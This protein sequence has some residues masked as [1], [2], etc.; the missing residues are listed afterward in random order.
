MSDEY[1]SF[2]Q[3]HPDAAKYLVAGDKMILVIEGEAIRIVQ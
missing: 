3:A 2:V 1:F